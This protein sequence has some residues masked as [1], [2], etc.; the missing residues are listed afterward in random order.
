LIE[1]QAFNPHIFSSTLRKQRQTAL[2]RIGLFPN[3]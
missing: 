3:I 1:R 2:F